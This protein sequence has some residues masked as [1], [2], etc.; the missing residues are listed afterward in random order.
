LFNDSAL[1][2]WPARTILT[3]ALF[4]SNL[5]VMDYSLVVGVDSDKH[6]LVVGIVDYIRTF[7]WFV[8]CPSRCS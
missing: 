4:L 8:L 6:E 1:R 2:L 7:T 5:N 3:A